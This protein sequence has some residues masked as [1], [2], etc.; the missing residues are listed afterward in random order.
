MCYHETIMD[1][2]HDLI[3]TLEMT[4]RCNFRCRMCDQLHG[5]P[6]GREQGFMSR[7]VFDRVLESLEDFPVT[8]L[9]PYWVGESI[10]HPEF[11]E[12][13]A[14]LFAANHDN[15]LFRHYNLN[16][17]AALL[18]QDV[19][20]TLLDCAG[21]RPGTLS[22][23]PCQEPAAPGPAFPR[24]GA[25]PLRV[26]VPAPEGAGKEPCAGTN[27][28]P[29]TP[30]AG[31][32]PCNGKD[33]ACNGCGGAGVTDP[34]RV[35][36]QS[37]ALYAPDTFVRIHFSLDA[38]HPPTYRRIKG[39]AEMGRTEGNVR[40]FLEEYT[41]RGLEFP[42]FNLAIIVMEENRHEVAEFVRFWQ[43]ICAELKLPVTVTHDW[44]EGC[45][46]GIY[47]RR[48]DTDQG[49]AAAEA[50]H[51]QVAMELELVKE[52]PAGERIIRTN[53]V[54]KEAGQDHNI[55]RRPCSGPFKTPII[56]WT[57]EVSVCCFDVK[58]QH[59]IGD[60]K[61]QSLREIWTG[62]KAHRIRMAHIRKDF[63]NFPAC[64]GCTN[65]NTPLLPDEEIQ[66][67]LRCSGEDET[68]WPPHS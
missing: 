46:N 8:L 38:L 45:N 64:A 65:L 49:Q 43:R 19:T 54:L 3:L 23:N 10:L 36:G 59:V 29:D 37:P 50:M 51:R 22:P 4:D 32:L 30:D 33:S 35:A 44:P 20:N 16:T 55:G 47:V 39:A 7:N 12:M 66:D 52:V 60:I 21:G 58:L 28:F 11:E 48:L 14:A 53:A 18:D 67:Y 56:H 34:C 40:Y 63:R 26:N 25:S 15:R 27:R 41:R 42:K 2:M 6:H 17:N 13:T 5:S 24:A 31:D 61:T 62:E 1:F 9:T 68:L 57:G